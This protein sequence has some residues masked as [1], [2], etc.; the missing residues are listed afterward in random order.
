M[1]QKQI[2]EREKAIVR[3]SIA[4]GETSPVK[5]YRLA[6]AGTDEELNA[7]ASL[8]SVASRWWHSKKIATFHKEE[9]KAYERRVKAIAEK[10]L[11]D[12]ISKDAT[13]ANGGAVAAAGAIDYTLPENMARELNRIANDE[14]LDLKTRL[15]AIKS[16]AAFKEDKENDTHE[17]RRFYTPLRCQECAMYRFAKAC[18]DA[19]IYSRCPELEEIRGKVANNEY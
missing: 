19:D 6:Y 4:F 1:N 16:L 8:P 10:A 2:T 5:L 3:Y 15:D 9:V 7:I 18:D 11:S 12:Q 13:A 14:T 17:I